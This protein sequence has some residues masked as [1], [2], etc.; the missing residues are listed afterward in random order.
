MSFLK[1]A[2]KESISKGIN[3]AV[4]KA[5]KEAVEPAA[6]NLANKA[7]E[8]ME[9][10][11]EKKMEEVEK[12][13][14]LARASA[15]QAAAETGAAMS[16][17]AAEASKVDMNQLKSAFASLTEMAQG[18]ATEMSEK[19][20]VC[21]GCGEPVDA[22]KKFCPNCGTK[23]PEETLAQGALCPNCG[24]QNDIG[25]KFCSD[26][27]TKLP[28]AVAEE[29]AAQS[30]TESVMALWDEYMPH[31]TKWTQGGKDFYLENE[32]EYIRFMAT[33]HTSFAAVNAVKQ[34]SLALKE[35][36]FVQAGQYPNEG[37][38]YKMVDGVCYHVDLEHAFDGDSDTASLYF[39]E[40][41]PTGGFYY[42][43]GDE[44]KKDLEE[45]KDGFNA[46]KGLFGKK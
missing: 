24:K 10:F 42:K 15:K 28:S 20:K 33:F 1:R 31:Y 41:E 13:T 27:G 6:T 35:D 30:K 3:E 18:Y 17:A 7:A 43:K 19:Y 4:S 39:N 38:L 5:V 22:D 36:G 8:K 45:L 32:G 40:A 23:M 11:A 21:P 46:L 37:Q 25:T 29:Q 2:L 44:K 26:C 9:D 34:Y 16:E 12:Q 14:E